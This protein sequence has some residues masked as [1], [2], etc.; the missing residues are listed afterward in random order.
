MSYMYIQPLEQRLVS[1]SH[2]FIVLLCP[3]RTEVLDYLFHLHSYVGYQSL[4]PR[5]GGGGGGLGAKCWHV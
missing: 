4:H 3:F 5:G 1:I 2:G